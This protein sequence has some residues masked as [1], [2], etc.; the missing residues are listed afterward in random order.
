MIE[1]KP[2]KQ[3]GNKKW[4]SSAKKEKLVRELLMQRKKMRIN[5]EIS[6]PDIARYLGIR[7]YNIYAILKSMPNVGSIESIAKSK[8]GNKYKRKK[9]RLYFLKDDCLSQT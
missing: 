7:D 2:E 5:I 3:K 1:P 4:I 8:R 9:V 6:I